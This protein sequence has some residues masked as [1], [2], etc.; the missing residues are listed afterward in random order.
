MPNLNPF[1]RWYQ[2]SEEVVSHWKSS[3]GDKADFQSWGPV[4][5]FRQEPQWG[6]LIAEALG[7]LDECS[8]ASVWPDCFTDTWST[9]VEGPLGVLNP[10]TRPVEEQPSDWQSLTHRA[11]PE[12]WSKFGGYSKKQIMGPW[13]D[14]WIRFWRFSKSHQVCL[15]RTSQARETA[16][17]GRRYKVG[18]K[19]IRWGTMC[20]LL[21]LHGK[22]RGK[23][24]DW[25]GKAVWSELPC[26]GTRLHPGLRVI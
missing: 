6:Q 14:V 5:P 8:G 7:L 23:Y 16:R 3:R 11:L 2:D 4:G 10:W 20:T 26:Q 19:K 1:F 25:R 12:A 21:W 15:G 13:G 18:L 24:W 9:S 17:T 22:T